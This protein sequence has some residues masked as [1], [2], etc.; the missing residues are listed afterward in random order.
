M[1]GT[2]YICG[3]PIGNIEDITLRVLRTLKECDL[4]AAEDTRQSVKL[5][6]HYDIKT[7][8][9]SYHEHNKDEKGPKLLAQLMEGKN[10]ALVT[11]AGMPGISDPGEDMIKLCYENGVPVTVVPGAT[12]AVTALALLGLLFVAFAPAIFQRGNPLPYLAA[13]TCLSGQQ[14]FVLVEQN[15]REAVY[16]SPLGANPVYL[17]VAWEGDLKGMEFR[18]QMGAAYLFSD[19]ERSVAVQSEVY[20]GRWVVWEV[21]RQ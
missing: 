6:N 19:G 7:P 8:L 15:E 4:I 16:I 17:T 10:I 18:E 13:A 11:D 3:T 21:P 5:L 2:L 12:A 14:S 9:T 1:T 20:W